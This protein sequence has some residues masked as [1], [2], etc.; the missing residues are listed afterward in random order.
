[1][2]KKK[3][4]EVC[5][6][7][8]SKDDIY[9]AYCGANLKI[10]KRKWDQPVYPEISQTLNITGN[11]I[12]QYQ[13]ISQNLDLLQNI[14]SSYNEH[15]KYCQI[16]KAQLTKARNLYQDSIQMT[17]KEYE[18]VEKLKNLSLKSIIAGL[19]GNREEQI[20]KEELE[21][22]HALNREQAAKKDL[23]S[24]ENRLKIAQSELENLKQL[25]EKK[26]TLEQKLQVL[27]DDICA[28]V[29]DPIEDE[30][31]LKLSKLEKRKFPL[32][33]ERNR[34]KNALSHLNNAHFHYSSALNELNSAMS[35]STWDTFFGGGL[36]AD[37]IKHSRIADAR[38]AS[39]RGR[40]ALQLAYEIVPNLPR[41]LAARIEEINKFW[42][43]FFDN[44]FSDLNAREK[45][46]RS[47]Y[48]TQESLEGINRAN[49][50]LKVQIQKIDSEFRN[51]QSEISQTR[52]DLTKRRRSLID[53]ALQSKNS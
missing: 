23:E 21:Y 11:E 35:A 47:I 20:K 3:I 1:M 9:C 2:E 46:Q 41:I 40:R 37:A 32:E 16:L 8:V 5:G 22:F 36:F 27:I 50:W 25:V 31:E 24:L 33:Q 7:K 17:K 19:K 44:I 48:S 12:Q 14:E 6:A 42:D 49:S 26:K 34:Y 43:V 18:D 15:N 45:I 29:K 39:I 38:D 52:Q 13:E 10:Q 51:L 28:G 30:L 4:C 53:I